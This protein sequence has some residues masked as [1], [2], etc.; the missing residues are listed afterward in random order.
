MKCYNFCF[1]CGIDSCIDVQMGLI[2]YSMWKY[3]EVGCRV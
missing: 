2:L 1:G 3:K